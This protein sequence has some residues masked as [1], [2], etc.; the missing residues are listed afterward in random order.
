MFWRRYFGCCR[1]VR[2]CCCNNCWCNNSCG[3]NNCC[4]NICNSCG[5]CD[6]DDDDQSEISCGCC[7]VTLNFNCRDNG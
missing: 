1:P 4:N 5:C 7:N 3:C 2:W 6:D